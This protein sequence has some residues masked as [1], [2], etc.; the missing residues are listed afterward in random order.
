MKNTVM[1]SRNSS[2]G[3]QVSMKCKTAEA[4]IYYTTDGS[5]PDNTSNKYEGPFNLNGSF[6]L[7]TV[8]YREDIGYSNVVIRKRGTIVGIE[9]NFNDI[10]VCTRLTP[11]SDPLGLVTEE[12]TEEPVIATT[13]Q[14]GSSPFD[15]L[16]P[17]ETKRRNFVDNGSGVFVP[18]PWA[19]EV[20]FNTANN[21]TMTW[22]PEFWIKLTYDTETSIIRYYIADMMT[23][24]FLLHPGSGQYV[25]SFV[26]SNYRESKSGKS[27]E[28]SETIVEM[29]D[30]A[31]E[32]GAG[33]GII[34]IAQRSALQWLYIVEFN[35]FDSQGIFGQTSG[36]AGSTGSTDALGYHTGRYSNNKIVYR[37]VE[38][39]WNGVYEWTDGFNT[40]IGHHYVS[41]DR[42]N[43]ESDITEGYTDLGSWAMNGTIGKFKYFEDMPW[44][45]GV[46]ETSGD[47][48]DT[49]YLYRTGTY[50]LYCGGRWDSDSYY[51]LFCFSANGSSSNTSSSYGSRLSYKEPD[52]EAA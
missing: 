11:A 9:R 28:T 24:G 10:T 37:Y 16:A 42:D 2:G 33:W 43:Y 18:G 35:S 50:V 6:T 41:T 13:S 31:K 4:D 44:L 17:W 52:A 29:R 1:I 47:G 8:A 32:K 23:E 19:G 26:T 48:Y 39:L 5:T 38:D 34:D 22:I 3:Y 46:P 49:G 7:K 21:D 14:S 15:L 40:V 51:G 30:Y 36:T 20:G 45:I 25:G 27:F 12:I